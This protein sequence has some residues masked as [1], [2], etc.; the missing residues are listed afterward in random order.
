MLLHI[1]HVGM[2]RMHIDAMDAVT[3]LRILVGDLSRT[4]SLVDRL[5][6]TAAVGGPEGA[7]SGDRHR[8]AVGVDWMLEDRVQAHAAGPGLPLR[9]RVVLTQGRQL[10]PL[11][12][13]IDGLEKSRILGTGV[14]R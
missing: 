14:D 8:E 7:R 9:T 12:A 1:E 10:C 13:S 6:G 3:H 2:G 4:E 11:P 5:P